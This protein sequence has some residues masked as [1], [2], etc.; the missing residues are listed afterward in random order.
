MKERVMGG[1]CDT[2]GEGKN[3]YI[4]NRETLRRPRRKL[5]GNYKTNFNKT[6]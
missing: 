2:H 3:A 6:V 4:L 5:E 1:P